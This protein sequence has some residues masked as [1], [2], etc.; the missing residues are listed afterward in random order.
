MINSSL[1][2]KKEPDTTPTLIIKFRNNY[3]KLS[4]CKETNLFNFKM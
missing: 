4:C 3:D 1:I 2:N